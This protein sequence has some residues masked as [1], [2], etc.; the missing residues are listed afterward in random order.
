MEVR[1]TVNKE[2]PL[3]G[4]LRERKG[5]TK[6]MLKTKVMWWGSMK[7]AGISSVMGAIC[8]RVCLWC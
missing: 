3:P 6:E 1:G 4:L 8:K 2:P 7:R 5:K